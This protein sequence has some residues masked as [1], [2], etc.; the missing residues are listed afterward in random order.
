MKVGWN[1]GNTLEAIGGETAW[2]NPLTTQT[3]IDSVKSAGFNAVRIPVAWSKFSN[4]QNFV[5]DES[6][7]NRVEEVTNYVLDAGMYAIINI[8][9]DGGWI[10]PTYQQ[11]AYVNNRLGI[12]WNQI[13][14]RF[15][16]Y[17]D[18]LLFAGT[19]EIMVTGNYG[20]PTKENYTVQNGYNQ[21]FVTTVRSTGGK[22]VY[23]M[24]VVQ[25]YNTNIDHTLNYAVMPTDVIKNHLIMEVH[26]YD[27]YDFTINENSK[28]TQWGKIA[29]DASKTET[30]ANE[31]YADTKFNQ[32]KTKFVDNGIPVIVGEYAAMARTD[33]A[34]HS[35]YR[36]YYLKY[37]TQSM[38]NHNIIPFYWDAGF[39]GNHGSGLFDRKTGQQAYPG[40]I[41]AI[42]GAVK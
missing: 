39:T 13:A 15:Q 29:T 26:Y 27:P 10:Q 32:M 41:K 18:H 28:I 37:I 7:M 20:T 4:E 21:T 8:H 22:N 38:I 5:I 23:R 24:L 3:L 6:F 2:G 36:E 40:I 25:G 19:N 33:V 16:D 14:T 11:Q 17:G 12:M 1:L 31:T 42:T 30:W 34:D 9:W 35:I